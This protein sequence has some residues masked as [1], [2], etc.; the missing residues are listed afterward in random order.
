MWPV[1]FAPKTSNCVPSARCSVK[2]IRR[3]RPMRG[4]GVV[5]LVLVLKGR[6]PA[7]VIDA[8]RRKS[9]AILL[10][11]PVCRGCEVSCAGR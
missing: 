2:E 8:M 9:T 10:L 11:Q 4:L 1:G 6:R 3:Q 7:R 5:M